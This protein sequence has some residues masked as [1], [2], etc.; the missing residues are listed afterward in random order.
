MLLLKHVKL[1]YRIG[2][3]SYWEKRSED[4]TEI[5]R[6]TW[7]KQRSSAVNFLSVR[8]TEHFQF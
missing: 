3:L 5:K 4:E 2:M 6:Q 7:G 1:A 8:P